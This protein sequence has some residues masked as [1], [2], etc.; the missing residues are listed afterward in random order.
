MTEDDLHRLMPQ[1]EAFH[2]RFH[3]YFC[4]SE[5]RAWSQ[6][7]VIGLLLPL[8]RKNVENIA[9]QVDAPSRKLQAFV[10]ESPWDDAGCIRELQRAVGE[11]MGAPNGVLILDDTGFPKKGMYSAGV[12]RQYSGTL[13]RT[14]NCQ[15]GVFLSYAS[16]HGHTLVDRRLY[17]L[18]E[19]FVPEAEPRR[20]RAGLPKDLQFQTKLALGREMLEAAHDTG[21]L[22]HQWVTGDAAYGECHDLRAAVAARGKWYCFEVHATA[23]V[24]TTDPGWQIPP[25]KGK[26]G[27]KPTRLQPTAASPVPVTV[28]QLAATLPTSAWRRHRV[29]EG[30]KG[31]REYEFA[32]VRVIERRHSQPGPAGWMLVRRPV[33]AGLRAVKYYLSNAPE[34]VSLAEMAWVGCLRWTVEENF[35]LAKGETGLDHYEVTKYRG[36]Y[37][38][39]TLSLLALAFLKAV[40]R[41]WGKKCDHGHRPGD[42]GD[43]SGRSP[44]G[45]VDSTPDHCLAPPAA[46]PQSGRHRGTPAAL[47]A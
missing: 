28:A 1:L 32:R 41:E 34:P 5:G 37:H 45:P 3:A 15:V 27:R 9:E 25:A 44:S 18:E 4:R 46:T 33:G 16:S 6:Q 29:C 7:Y 17:V 38:H 24:W 20:V 36:W 43:A 26:R 35:E 39:I 40:Q 11:Q 22:P 12:G 21:H 30:A 14:D 8:E 23:E 13:G 31:P 2:A 42:S 19:W 10:S 47:A